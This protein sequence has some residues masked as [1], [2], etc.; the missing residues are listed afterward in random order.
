MEKADIPLLI[1]A[2]RMPPEFVCG[3]GIVCHATEGLCIPLKRFAFPCHYSDMIPFFGR[4]VP[5]FSIISNE[6]TDWLYTNH[7]HRVTHWNHDILN[8]AVLVVYAT[9]INNKGAALENCFGFI[10]G[11]VRPISRP[12]INQT[13]V[14]NEHKRVHALKFQSV[15]K[16]MLLLFF[17]VLKR[18]DSYFSTILFLYSEGRM[19]DARMVALSNLY[20][21]LE[22]FAFSPTGAEMCLYGDPAY[23]LRVHLQAPFRIGILTRDM[24]IFNDSMSAVRVSVGW[25]FADIINHFKFLDFKKDLKIGLSQVGKMYIV[26]VLLRKALTCLY[27]NSTAEYFGLVPPTLDQYF[28]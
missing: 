16:F 17:P 13:A 12:I 9:A 25:L 26:C 10:D 1:D 20:D 19:H 14:Y 6:I 11:T 7:G 28:S 27:S 18:F 5:E 8:P 3:N 2:L 24:Q 4:S 23:P 15:A 21:E 22:N